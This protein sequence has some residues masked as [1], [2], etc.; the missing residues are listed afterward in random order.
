ML[1]EIGSPDNIDKYIELFKDKQSGYRLMG[2]GHRVYKN[3]DP[4]AEVLKEMVTNVSK[5]LKNPKSKE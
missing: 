2:F 4:R 5:L 3:Y 1:E